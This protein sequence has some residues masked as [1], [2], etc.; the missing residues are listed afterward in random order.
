MAKGRFITFEG[1]EG[2]GKSTQVGLLA[3]AL[4]AAGQTVLET[5]EP[6][7]NEAAEEIRRL[8]V[9]GATTRWDALTEALLHFAARREHLV[10]SVWPAL[11]KGSWVVCDRFADSTMAYQGYGSGV[12]IEALENLYALVVGDFAP[13]LTFVLDLPVDLGLQRATSAQRH[14]DRYL[15]MGTNFHERVRQG[16]VEYAKKHSQRTVVIDGTKSAEQIF[17][18]VCALVDERLGSSLSNT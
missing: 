10:Q 15:N 14:E 3:S 17:S 12:N 18:A 1:G 11:E 9:H 7:G 13:D 5:R 4:R 6:G 16:F 8:L 2:A